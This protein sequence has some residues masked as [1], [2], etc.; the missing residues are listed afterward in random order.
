MQASQTGPADEETLLR[1]NRQAVYCLQ[2]PLLVDGFLR[3]Q[4][5]FRIDLEVENVK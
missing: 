3:T 1:F 4:E 5:L 2:M